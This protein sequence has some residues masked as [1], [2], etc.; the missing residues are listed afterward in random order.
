MGLVDLLPLVDLWTFDN[1]HRHITYRTVFC[2][3]NYTTHSIN[4]VSEDIQFGLFIYRKITRVMS[5]GRH[6]MQIRNMPRR[7]STNFPKIV[8]QTHHNGLES[9]NNYRTVKLDNS[10]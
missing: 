10:V 9:V 1:Q 6:I 7:E 3:E 4:G 2:M 8:Q 5:M